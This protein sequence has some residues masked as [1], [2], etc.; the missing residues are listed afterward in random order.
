VFSG[1]GNPKS[2]DDVLMNA[3]V[4]VGKHIVFSDHHWYSESD[5]KKIIDARNQGKADFILTTEKDVQRL[6]ERFRKFLETEPVIVA[7]IQQEII[8]GEQTLDDVIKRI[9]ERMNDKKIV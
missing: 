3:G 7:E 6:R 1:I 2:F 8:S 5:I 9:D 4:T